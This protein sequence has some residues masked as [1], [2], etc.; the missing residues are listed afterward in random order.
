MEAERA[1]I[2][3]PTSEEREAIANWHGPMGWDGCIGGDAV[4]NTIKDSLNDASS[5]Q[6]VSSKVTGFFEQKLGV[7]VSGTGYNVI[8]VSYRAK[9]GFGA[10]ML[11]ESKI[12]WKDGKIIR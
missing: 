9:N 11:N 2:V 5:Y 12:T 4:E 1:S 6:Y 7:L 3:Q 10:Y 8:S